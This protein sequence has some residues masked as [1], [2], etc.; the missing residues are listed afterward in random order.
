VH[1]DA[2]FHFR[3]WLLVICWAVCYLLKLWVSRDF[4]G[5]FNYVSPIPDF[6]SRNR[7][8]K[9]VEFRPRT[10]WEFWCWQDFFFIVPEKLVVRLWI[11]N[12]TEWF[13]ILFLIENG[14]L[15][16]IQYWID[17]YINLYEAINVSSAN[18]NSISLLEVEMCDWS[19]VCRQRE[20]RYNLGI[21]SLEEDQVTR[22]KTLHLIT[23]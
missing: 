2:S 20:K 5:R 1:K 18:D 12:W 16:F 23:K 6:Y 13:L 11:K 14:F 4:L 10:G 7:E 8:Q 17:A 21:I 15:N 9:R 19:L 3:L 22:K